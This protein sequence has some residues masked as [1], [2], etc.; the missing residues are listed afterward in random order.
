[1]PLKVRWCVIAT[2]A[3]VALMAPLA[4]VHAYDCQMLPSYMDDAETNLRRATRATDL[5]EAQRYAR[6]AE[7]ALEDASM[8]AMNCECV[9]AYSSLDDAATRARRAKNADEADE[10][11]EQLRRAIRS[12]NDAIDA[13]QMCAAE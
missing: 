3:A 8:A 1:V 10:F 7:S 12:Y 11:I 5:D 6:R 4:A 2:T 9:L 13:L